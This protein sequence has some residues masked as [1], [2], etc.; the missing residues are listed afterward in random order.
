LPCIVS[1]VGGPKDLVEPGIT[2]AITRGLDAKD[3]AR[4]TAHIA[5]DAALREVMRA[6]CVKAV[7]SRDWQEA[8]RRWWQAT[9]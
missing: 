9:S 8:A 6:A 4:A 5:G 2:G 7:A 3:F 1:D